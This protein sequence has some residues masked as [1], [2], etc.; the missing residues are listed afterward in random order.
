M[1]VKAGP[2][3]SLQTAYFSG[4][5][6]SVFRFYDSKLQTCGVQITYGAGSSRDSIQIADS[7][8]PAGSLSGVI[9]RVIGKCKIY[10]I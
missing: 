3:G 10:K 7:Y 9:S 4:G 8:N 1:Q 6:I 5:I 2:H